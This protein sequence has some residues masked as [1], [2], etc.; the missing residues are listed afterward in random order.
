[1]QE[2]FDFFNGSF[3]APSMGTRASFYS[4]PGVGPAAVAS[5]TNIAN[6]PE[7]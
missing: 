4:S 3:T 6:C 2:R 1:M 7:L 5:L